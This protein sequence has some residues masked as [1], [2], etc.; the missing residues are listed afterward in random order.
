MTGNSH[1]GFLDIFGPDDLEDLI[2]D[3]FT[4]LLSQSD[5]GRGRGVQLRTGINLSSGL[6][7][8][9]NKEGFSLRKTDTQPER[10]H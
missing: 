10:T 4:L 1:Q 2:S 3:L 6:S 5:E 8:V 9:L 7:L